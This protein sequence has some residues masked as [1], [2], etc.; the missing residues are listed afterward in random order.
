MKVNNGLMRSPKLNW[1]AISNKS[2][3]RRHAM[4][5]EKDPQRLLRVFF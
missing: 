2:Q 4:E 3:G 5:K 1:Q